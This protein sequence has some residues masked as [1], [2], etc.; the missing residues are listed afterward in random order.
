MRAKNVKEKRSGRCILFTYL[1]IG[2]IHLF[3][4]TNKQWK[5]LTRALKV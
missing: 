4:G 5:M 1:F 3:V 2:G